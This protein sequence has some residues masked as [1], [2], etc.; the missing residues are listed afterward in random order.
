MYKIYLHSLGFS[1]KEAEVYMALNTY[2]ATPASTLA[3]ITN[4]KRTSMYDVLNSLLDK[5]LIST[6]KKDSNTYYVIDDINKVVYQERDKMRL[7]ET[8]VSQMK[9]ERGRKGDIEVRNY[10]GEEGFRELYEEILR[11]KPPELM[12]WMHLDEFYHAIDPVRE[13]EWTKERIE[14]GIGARLILQDTELARNFSKGN[15]KSSRETIILPK[16]HMYHTTCFLYEGTILLM[17]SHDEIT[18]IQIKHPGFYEM[19]KQ[20]FEMNWKLF[21]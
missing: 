17:D 8:V 11:I 16:E 13:D 12:A 21:S 18:G 1:E 19:Q 9:A 2:G 14:K 20:I 3:R 5:N 6:Y 15:A 10:K 7:A 4:I